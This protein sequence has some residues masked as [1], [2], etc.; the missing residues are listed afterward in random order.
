LEIGSV[1]VGGGY[2]KVEAVMRNLEIANVELRT[3]DRNCK[4]DIGKCRL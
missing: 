2:R 3:G 1:E 4:F